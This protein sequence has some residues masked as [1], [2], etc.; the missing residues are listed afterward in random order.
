MFVGCMIINNI[1]CQVE[2]HVSVCSEL[3]VHKDRHALK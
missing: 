2:W 1:L 3:I